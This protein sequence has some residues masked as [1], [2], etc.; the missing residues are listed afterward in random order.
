MMMGKRL[1]SCVLCTDMVKH[2]DWRTYREKF[3]QWQVDG[4]TALDSPRCACV[5]RSQS[6]GTYPC[7]QHGGVLSGEGGMGVKYW[8]HDQ[9]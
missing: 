3:P 4:I 7:G 1:P 8:W 5:P 6:T 9:P 2:P